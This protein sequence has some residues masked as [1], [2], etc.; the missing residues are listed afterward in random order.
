MAADPSTI[1]RHGAPIP[2]IGLLAHVPIAAMVIDADLRIRWHNDAAHRALTAGPTSDPAVPLPSIAYVGHDLTEVIEDVGHQSIAAGLRNVARSRSGSVER[3]P[4]TVRNSAGQPVPIELHATPGLDETVVI[5]IVE[6]RENSGAT[7]EQQRDFRSALLEL[8]ELSHRHID[9]TRFYGVLLQRSI[10]VIPGAEAGSILLRVDDSDEYEFVAAQGFDID[11]LRSRRIRSD[12]LIDDIENPK[13]TIVRRPFEGEYDVTEATAEWFAEVGRTEE[14]TSSISA[15]VASEG[16]A[17]AYLYL[18][19]FEASNPFTSVS[20]EMA[21]VLSRLI[22]DLI[23]RRSLEA[24]LRM[25]R[26]SFKHLALHDGLTGLANRRHVEAAIIDAV[27][28]PAGHERPV[29]VLFADVDDFKRINDELGHDVGDRV[30]RAVGDAL[31]LATRSDDVVGRWGGDE[32]VVVATGVT[33]RMDAHRLGQRVLEIFGDEL[34]LED[35]RTVA[36]RLSIGVVWS[37]GR[38]ESAHGLL[39]R[40]DGALYEAKLAGKGV[41][42]LDDGR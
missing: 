6:R 1:E 35:G 32:F 7:L 15:P 8:S 38:D 27:S 29:A 33:N 25:E 10:E 16:T 3:L 24:E 42:R 21:T 14:I 12:E 34:H 36:C 30:L 26:E 31:R 37:D 13:A 5:Q 28:A 22:A 40:A 9:D 2:P 11:A 18:D 17:I 41:V 23:R 19:S 39:R 4:A 20:L